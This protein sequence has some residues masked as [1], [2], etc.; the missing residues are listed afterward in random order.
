MTIN[1]SYEVLNPRGLPPA[2]KLKPLTPRV[3]DLMGKVIYIANIN[4]VY[5]EEVLEEVAK[6]IRQRF[7]GNE[8]VHR[9]MKNYYAI[10]D[11]EL[12]KEIVEKGNAAVVGPG[13]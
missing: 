10:D 3:Q 5:A 8:V 7:P 1:A 9:M 12:W 13:D 2:V 11:P 6:S 4:K